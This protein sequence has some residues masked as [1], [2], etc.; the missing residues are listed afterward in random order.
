VPEVS[1]WAMMIMG[2][3]TIGAMLRL[4]R[5]RTDVFAAR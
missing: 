3:G 5:R 1:T 2:F 4:Q